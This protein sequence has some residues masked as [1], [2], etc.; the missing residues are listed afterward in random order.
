MTQASAPETAIPPQRRRGVE[1]LRGSERRS[2]APDAWKRILFF[3]PRVLIVLYLVAIVM[4][5]S[6]SAGGTQIA[7]YACLLLVFL[8]PAF[9][10]WMQHRPKPIML[11]LFMAL[12]VLWIAVAIYHV[13]GTTKLVFTINQILT[14]FG[15]YVL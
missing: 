1:R 7:P 2:A 5:L 15:T 9:L 3:P 14:L 11:D 8:V 4:P 13:H 6:A 12:Y 10:Y